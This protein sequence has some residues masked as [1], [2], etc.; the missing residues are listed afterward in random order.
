MRLQV[1]SKVVRGSGRGKNEG[2]DLLS[3]FLLSALTV[4]SQ[5]SSIVH[6][7]YSSN[8]LSQR[9]KSTKCLLSFDVLTSPHTSTDP[10]LTTSHVSLFRKLGI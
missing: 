6:K 9:S 2:T 7:K 10:A 3:K 4:H 1:N 8:V 5:S